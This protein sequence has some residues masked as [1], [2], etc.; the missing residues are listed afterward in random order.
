MKR[1]LPLMIALLLLT[2]CSRDYLPSYS[3]E[4]SKETA[5]TEETPV[6]TGSPGS[7]ALF[8]QE[9]SQKHGITILIGQEAAAVEPWDY[10]FQPEQDQKLMLDA[11]TLLDECLKNYP[12]GMLDVLSRD[13]GGISVCLVKEIR[14]KENTGSLDMAKGLQ[15]RDQEGRCYLMLAQDLEYTLYHE[16]CHVIEDFVL[17]R[18]AAWD[19]WESLNPEGFSYDLDL[20]KNNLRDEKQYL[21]DGSRAFIDTYSMSFPQED[22]ARIMEYAMTSGNEDLF[23]FPVMQKKL[24]ILTQGIREAFGLLDS[25]E[26]FRW[27]Q[28][29]NP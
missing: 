20:Q 9:L 1:F 17:P 6:E 5:F 28:Y 16:L 7:P 8:A 13:C 4:E 21:N 27:E 11:L 29:L 23:S 10:S 2:G 25:P 24:S 22:R 15:F 3:A 18:S 12:E 14:G 19:S 26:I